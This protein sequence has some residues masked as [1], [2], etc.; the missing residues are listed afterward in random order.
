MIVWAGLRPAPPFAHS[1]MSFS[2]SS[3]MCAQDVA[4]ADKADAKLQRQATK[5]QR[6]ASKEPARRAGSAAASGQLPDPAPSAAAPL[7]TLAEDRPASRRTMQRL[8]DTVRE[9]ACLL[10]AAC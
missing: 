9:Q 6:R 1:T 7:P 3:M 10:H 2:A 4:R 5:E 8:P